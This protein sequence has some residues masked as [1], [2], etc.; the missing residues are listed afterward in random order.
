M[1]ENKDIVNIVKKNND[2]FVTKVSQIDQKVQ[3]VVT[4]TETLLD[5]YKKKIGDIGKNLESTK[6]YRNEVNVQLKN[7]RNNLDRLTGDCD[8]Y[9]L[10]TKDHLNRLSQRY[11]ESMVDM[12]SANEG[13]ERE[14][15]RVQ[16]LFRE[17]QEEFLSQLELKREHNETLLRGAGIPDTELKMAKN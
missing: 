11:A 5:Q 16:L 1:N 13:F 4:D 7:L 3:K 2:K 14:L 12:K 6:S 15:E 17:L 9:H 8:Q 10:D